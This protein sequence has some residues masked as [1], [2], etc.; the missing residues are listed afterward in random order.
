MVEKIRLSSGSLRTLVLGT[1]PPC[2]EEDQATWKDQATAP[3]RRPVDTNGNSQRRVNEAANN[4]ASCLRVFQLR[5]KASRSR[6][7][8]SL[9]CPV[10]IPGSLSP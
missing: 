3:S 7:K 10:G 6:D 1:Q 5:P 4:S 9:Q 8:L 2:C